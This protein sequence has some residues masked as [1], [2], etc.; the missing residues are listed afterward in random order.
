M[1]DTARDPLDHQRSSRPRVGQALKNPAKAPGVLLGGPESWRW[2]SVSRASLTAGLA[3]ES[4][5]RRCR[6]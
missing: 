2:Q 1:G 3:P 5:P 6:C 4:P